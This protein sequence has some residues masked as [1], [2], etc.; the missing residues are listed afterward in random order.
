MHLKLGKFL[1]AMAL[2]GTLVLAGQNVASAATPWL[3]VSGTQLKDP[4]GN[5]VILRG[6]S[7][8]DLA[9]QN[10]SNPNIDGVIDKITNKNDGSSSSPGWYPKV[11]RLPVEPA[12]Y[13]SNSWQPG[14]DTF[15][16]N[17]LRPTVNYCKSKD[18]YCIID[19]HYVDNIDTNP[20]YV[21]QF[22]AYIAQKFAGDSNVLFEL[23]NEP[24][25]TA[26]TTNSSDTDKWNAVRGYQQTFYNTVRQYASNVCLIGTPQYS[27]ILIPAISNPVSGYNI[28]Y[29]VHMY[30]QHFFSS[31]NVNQ[32]DT[33]AGK[34]PLMMTEWGYYPSSDSLYAGATQ[35][36]Y[37]Q[38]LLQKLDNDGI[39]WTAWV[40]SN[41]WG[42]PMFDSN[43]NLRIG[44]QEMGG[45][46]KDSLYSRRNN[47]QP[48]DPASQTIAN[49]IYKIV[50]RNS[51][52]AL[53][54]YGWGT[55]NGTLIDQ[56]IYGSG[57]NQRWN[58]TYLGG[59]LYNILNV[60][61]NKPL[62]VTG[63]S[64]GSGAWM[65]LWDNNGGAG[66]KWTI[67][68]ASG[69]YY[70]VSPSYNSGLALDVYGAFTGNYNPSVS[71]TNGRID[72]Y[73]SSGNANQQWAFG[74]P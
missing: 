66:Q 31:Y 63:G 14:S 58:V 49:G 70:K 35:S 17:V 68:A 72:V 37:G 12:D 52:L 73:T 65:E 19:M 1:G 28:V 36:N 16:N 64:S 53:D 3:S 47:N 57:N 6:I 74:T 59:G 51:G 34:I 15:Y 71:A 46:V 24:V 7:L 62:D 45:F 33:A 32:L 10:S 67:T 4:N 43:W 20:N 13:N 54:A 18:V 9:S 11:L 23:Y 61:A 69:G 21:N 56:Y 8:I 29:V 44:Q 38:P 40:A 25:A 41:S 26:S 48:S 42:P 60:N 5:V 39:G 2:L 50:N 30:P 27:Q 55:A 22:W